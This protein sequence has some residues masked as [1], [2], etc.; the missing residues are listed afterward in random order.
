M[1]RLRH[2]LMLPVLGALL[3]LSGCLYDYA[4]SGPV[5]SIDTWLLGQWSTQ[6]K[7]G[8]QF[9]AI[10]T[11]TDS[12]HYHIQFNKPGA[13]NQEF[14]AWLSRVDDFSIL[15]LRSLNEGATFGKFALYHTE[16]LTQSP[17]PV[18]GIGSNR[19][20]LSELQLDE[21]TRSLDSTKLRAA[22]RSALKAGTLLLPHD[23]V[24]DMKSGKDEIP[25]SVIWT[26]TGSV[27]FGGETF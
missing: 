5:R 7:S 11:R 18:G 10:V 4:P 27:T 23:V 16:L 2:L 14:D 13:G 24:A 3:T 19:I 25:G 6:D 17:A 22:I 12:D 1:T 21:S 8:H 26:K 20:R 9:S 15:V